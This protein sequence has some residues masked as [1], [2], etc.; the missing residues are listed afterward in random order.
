MV[1][2]AIIGIPAFITSIVG[3]NKI[4]QPMVKSKMD[5]INENKMIIRVLDEKTGKT[6]NI[7]F[8]D[9]IKGVLAAEMPALF[10]IEALKAQAVAARTYAVKKMDKNK[11]NVA[12]I[13]TEPS[14]GQAYLSIDEL[15]EKWGENFYTYYEKITR[16][17]EDTKGQVMFYEEEPIEAVFHSTSAGMTQSAKDVWQADVPY[18]QSVESDGDKQAPAFE[19]EKKIKKEDVI[20]ILLTRYPDIIIQDLVGQIQIVERSSGGYIK[21]IQIGNKIL[22]GEE[23]REIFKLKSSAFI[24]K[25]EGENIIFATKGYGHG[26]GMS[27][28]GANYMAKEG[29]T[30]KE[31]LNHY[32]NGIII[33]EIKDYDENI[34]N[35]E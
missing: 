5:D 15:K 23:A 2:L 21:Y 30:Y 35:D 25:E 4:N 18:L 9:Y 19:E 28:Y 7:E 12:D 33:K 1:F 20:E 22:T 11:D 29:R 17:V 32:Y 26:A 24:L 34:L 10:E 14:K 6:N 8:E 3:E 13:S 16:A 31:I 27:Q